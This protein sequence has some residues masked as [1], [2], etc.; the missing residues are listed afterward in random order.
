LIYSTYLG[1][2]GF[3]VAFGIALDKAGSA[4]VTGYTTATDFPTV[5]AVQSGHGS[6]GNFG[7]ED[8]RD[9]FVTKFSPDGRSLLY[10][11]Y[12]GGDRLDIGLAIAVDMAG[13]AYVVGNTRSADFPLFDAL[14]CEIVQRGTAGDD[15]RDGFVTKL[16]PTGD[17]LEYST[18]LG[19]ESFDTPEAAAIGARG[20]LH[21]AGWT[22]S[23]LF[24]TV[25]PVQDRNPAERDTAFIATLENTD[26]STQP[27]LYPTGAVAQAGDEQI[28]LTWNLCV[29]ETTYNVYLGTESGGQGP[30]PVQSDITGNSATLSGLS[31]KTTYYLEV[32]GVNA[33]GE[34]ERSAEVSATP[35]LEVPAQV[36]D[37]VVTPGVESIQIRWAAATRAEGYRV[38]VRTTTVETTHDVP[39]A[40]TSYVA[41]NLNAGQPYAVQ[42]AG[43]NRS[44][45][46]PK[47][48]VARVTPLE[49]E[50]GGG[51]GGGGSSDYLLL[52]WLGLIAALRRRNALRLGFWFR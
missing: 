32:A 17:M 47:S 34:G 35:F 1:G 40:P 42:I 28:V 15:D 27:P 51:G 13:S 46:G 38:Y 41:L 3:N 16:N 10:S 52:A 23:K 5:N 44:G 8:G 4:Y 6:P 29:P 31:N 18:F 49:P 11:T 39:A 20:Q 25:V 26:R 50:S 2:Y 36:A 48:V 24:P 22:A 37:V 12:L 14:Q 7:G 33:A 21:I 19:G 43:I 30:V 9:A 45:L